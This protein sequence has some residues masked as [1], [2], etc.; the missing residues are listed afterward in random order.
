MDRS[1][2]DYTNANRTAWN[3]AAPYHATH[4]NERLLEQCKARDFVAFK[5]EILQT[6]KRVGVADKD[7]IQ[8]CCN[9]G[10]ETLSLHNM[11]AASC[12]GVDA[13]EAFLEHAREF[14][15]VA[16]A[17]ERVSFLH[18]DVYQLPDQLNQSFDMVLVTIGVLSWMPDLEGFFEVAQRLLKPGGHLVIED[19]HP[20]LFMYDEDSEGGASS[21]QFSYFTNEVWK[22]TVSLDYFSKVEYESSLHYSFM[23]RTDDILMA[24]INNNLQ[25]KSFKELDYDISFFCSD[26][27]NSPTKPPLGFV[28]VMQKE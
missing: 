3:Q 9:N 16:G 14:V 20:V 8:L 2:T 17:H 15:Q 13:A 22:E 5:G 4:N 6:L 18:S 11:G 1:R 12:L 27:E 25:L 19:M 28:M 10:I 24:G 21:I 7:I 23:H 26:L